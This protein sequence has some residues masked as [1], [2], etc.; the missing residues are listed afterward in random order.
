MRA[1]RNGWEH[2]AQFAVNNSSKAVAAAWA[3]DTSHS[4]I[5]DDENE[6]KRRAGDVPAV[7]LQLGAGFIY[8]AS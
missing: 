3:P 1:G 4:D 2:R 6:Q 5:H 8:G 7:G